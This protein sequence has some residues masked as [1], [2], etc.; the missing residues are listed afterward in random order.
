M[1][2]LYEVLELGVASEVTE[3]GS[4]IPNEEDEVFPRDPD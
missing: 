2:E 4:V 1:T 3:G